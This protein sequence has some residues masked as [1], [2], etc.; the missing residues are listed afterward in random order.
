MTLAPFAQLLVAGGTRGD[1]VT[2]GVYPS[3]GTGVL[4]FYDMIR[5]DVSRGLRNG[6]WQFSVDIDR[7]F[8]GLL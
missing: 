6:Y 2:S 4:F 3:V 1:S 7:G 5:F 8:W